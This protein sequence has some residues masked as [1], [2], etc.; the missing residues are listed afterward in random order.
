MKPQYGDGDG[1]PVAPEE[2]HQWIGY[3]TGEPRES[4]TGQARYCDPVGNPL[5]VPGLGG[6]ALRDGSLVYECESDVAEDD[7]DTQDQKGGLPV[8]FDACA[9]EVL[10]GLKGDHPAELVPRP[11]SDDGGSGAGGHG[12]AFHLAYLLDTKG[13]Q[14]DVLRSGR[15]CDQKADGDDARE[16]GG[17]VDERP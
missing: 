11:P 10:G 3:G 12:F 1:E 14:G 5:I 2:T 13:I 7:R 6:Q 15:E 4:T 16:I 9:L 17:R 8:V